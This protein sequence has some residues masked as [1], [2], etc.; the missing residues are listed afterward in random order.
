MLKRTVL[1]FAAI[2]ASTSCVPPS[3]RVAAPTAGVPVRD[4]A[5]ARSLLAGLALEAPAEPLDR[6]FA[7]SAA[8]TDDPPRTLAAAPAFPGAAQSD[9]DRQRAIACLTAAVYYEARSEPTDG[10]RAV[11]QVVLNRV[12][13]RAFPH[14][15]CGV[16]YQGSTRRTGCQFSFTCDG[17][18][19]HPRDGAAWARAASVA[20]AAFDGS[21]FAPVGASTS[22]HAASI[23]PWWAPSLSRVGAVGAHIFYRWRGAMERALSF[24][25]TYAGVE[26]TRVAA[27]DTIL[28]ASP[29][30][31]TELGTA[32]SGVT[33]H[34]GRTMPGVETA[35]STPP[36]SPAAAPRVHLASGVRI[37]IGSAHASPVLGGGAPLPVV[38]ISEE[39]DP[40]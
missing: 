30:A 9:D 22:Y 36:E 13:D 6:A 35:L 17:S 14:S 12:R 19:N 37:H 3:T 7:G 16:V 28:A 8:S 31:S 24:R 34:R 1:G 26:P 20:R 21:V 15:V 40:T 23:L 29:S 18:M 25:Q 11:A 33:V 4:A 5:E 39:S 27:P 32:G 38:S 10:Q 2:A